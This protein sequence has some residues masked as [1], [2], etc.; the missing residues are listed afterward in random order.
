[1][2]PELESLRVQSFVASW[3]SFTLKGISLSIVRIARH[4]FILVLYAHITH[5][6]LVRSMVAHS[7]HIAIIYTERVTSQKRRNRF[8]SHYE[9]WWWCSCWRENCWCTKCTIPL[10]S[11][12]DWMSN[13]SSGLWII[14]MRVIYFTS[15][16]VMFFPSKVILCNYLQ[17]WNCFTAWTDWLAN[18]K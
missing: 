3:K 16:G 17:I 5:V 6:L 2:L 1:M 11:L 9:R 7:I 18:I 13:A 14:L 10:N 15:W 8:R 12:T 4:A